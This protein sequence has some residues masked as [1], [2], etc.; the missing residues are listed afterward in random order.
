MQ[1]H[2]SDGAA[3]TFSGKQLTRPVLLKATRVVPLAGTLVSKHLLYRVQAVTID[4]NNLVN[5]AQQAFLPA[6]SQK[7]TLR[8]LFYSAKFIAR[9]RIFRFPIGSS[10]TL[11]YPNGHSRDYKLDSSKTLVLKALPRG[12]YRVTVHAAGLKMK[13]PVAMTR[14]QVATLNVVSYLDVAAVG[15]VHLRNR[16]RTVACRSPRPAAAPA[17]AV[18]PSHA[19]DGG[20][21]SARVRCVL[22]L[23][24]AGLLLTCGLAATAGAAARPIPVLAYYYIWYNPESWNRAKIDYPLLGRYSSDDTKVLEQHVRW[25]QYAGIDGFIVS[26]KHTPALDARLRKLIAIADRLDFKLAII[27]Q[28]LDFYRRPLPVARVAGRSPVL[29]VAFRE[30]S[31]VRPLLE[32]ARHLVR[33]LGVHARSGTAGGWAGARQA[34]RARVGEERRRL[35]PARRHRRRRRVLLVVG[36]SADGHELREQARRDGERRAP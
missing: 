5:R 23:V 21:M 17:P 35:Q 2:R 13:M 36:R 15:F 27:Y 10:I 7:V 3:F 29:R 19:R 33:H 1:L 22:A 12:N 14:D 6:E 4:G 30:R 32:A 26:W 28:G 16:G 34:S 25:A 18:R 8:L 9:D 24:A 31:R 20:G 11:E